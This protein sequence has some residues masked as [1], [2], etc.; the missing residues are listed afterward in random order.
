MA[1]YRVLSNLRHDLVE[2]KPGEQIELGAS[3]K[4]TEELL[5]AKVIEYVPPIQVKDEPVGGKPI[6]TF[7]APTS[8]AEIAKAVEKSKIPNPEVTCGKCKKKVRLTDYQVVKLKNDYIAVKGYCPICG[9]SIFRPY[10]K[11]KSG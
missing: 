4:A 7:H 10:G 3:E 9:T 11:A 6:D 2:Y 1:R 5:K 8:E